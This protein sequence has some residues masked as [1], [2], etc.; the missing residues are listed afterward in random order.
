MGWFSIVVW[1]TGLAVFGSAILVVRRDRVCWWDSG[2]NH[3]LE[4]DG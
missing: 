1:A 2:R 4:M 3:C